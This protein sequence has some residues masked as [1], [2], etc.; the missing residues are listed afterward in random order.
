MATEVAI[1]GVKHLLFECIIVR[2]NLVEWHALLFGNL[3][4]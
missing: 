4:D 3:M 1:K 2:F